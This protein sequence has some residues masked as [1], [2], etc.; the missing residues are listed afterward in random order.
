VA[1]T[2][3]N[4]FVTTGILIGVL[5]GA[6]PG[7]AQVIDRVLAIVDGRLV[8]LS[9]VRTTSTLKLVE[10][11]EGTGGIDAALDRW[12]ERLL[13]LQEVDRFSPPEPPASAIE[14][15]VAAV[16][17]ALGPPAEARSTLATLGVEEGWL[18]QWVRD[19]LRIQ[20]YT[21]QR[22]SGSLE[23]TDEEIEN[24]YREH[25][26]EIAREGTQALAREM[27]VAARRRAL[28]A[29]WMDGLRRR[30]IIVRPA[31]R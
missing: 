17:A 3:L 18:R 19:D 24:Y 25:A 8:T 23:P 5:L 4:R 14:T 16:L 28:V 13:V 9:D 15:R 27:V 26:P 10:A 11:P 31:A 22:F 20:S 6:V 21:D 2:G 1:L 29:D 30:A 7:G 12:I